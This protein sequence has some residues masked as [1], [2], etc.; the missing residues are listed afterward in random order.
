MITNQ[1]LVSHACGTQRSSNA[2]LLSSRSF[3]PITTL[4]VAAMLAFCCA[5]SAHAAGPLPAGGRFVG[6]NGS[7]AANGST[8]TVN[9]STGRG[10]VNWDSFSIGSGNQVVFANGSGAT[11]NRVTGGKPSAILG[12]LKASGSVYLINPQGIVVGTQGVIATN[13]RF[14]ASTLDTDPVAF[15]NGGPLTLA[16]NSNAGIVNLGKISSSGGDVFLIARSAI[17][18]NGTISAPNGTAEL[19]VAKQVLLQDSSTGKQVFVQAGAGGML[20]NTG[21][22]QAAQVSLQ[23]VDG[24]IYALAGNH[25]AIRATGTATRDGH[26]WLVA[27]HGT[28]RPGGVIDAKGGTVDMQANTLAFPVGGTNVSARQWNISTPTF[29]ID[30]NAANALVKGLNNGTSVNVQTTGANG[31]SGDLNVNAGIGWQ[32]GASLTLAAYHNVTVGSGAT[33]ANQ[34]SGN[35]TLRADAASH[36]NAGSIANHG[37]IDWSRSTGLVNALY[38]MNG[39]YSAG[40]LLGNPSWTAAASSGQLTQITGYKLVNN[41]ND[42]ENIRQDLAGNYALGTD[43][44]ATG[45][46]FTPIGDHTTPFTGQFDGMWH[47][48]SNATIDIDDFH[49][50]SSS[51]LFGVVGSAGVLRDV[52]MENG[53]VSTSPVGSGILAGVNDGV[54]AYAH[55]T[56]RA[57]EVEQNATTFGGL[58][59]KN[60]GTVERSWSS[61]TVSGSN[62]NGGLVGYN[63]GTI[64]QSYATGDV[65]PVFSTGSGGGLVGINDGTVSQSFATGAVQTRSMPTHG[66]IAFGSGTL[67]PDVYWNRETTGQSVSGGDLP[68]TNGLTTAQMSDKAS[69]AGYDFGPD[70]VWLMPSGATHPVLRQ[71]AAQ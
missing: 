2:L 61:A 59:G 15:M 23:S 16:G 60:D 65:S 56:G 20:A 17:M 30:R 40:T 47:T 22:I 58:V 67:A 45:H 18:N 1:R 29:T 24:N 11:L 3:H 49:K 36:D 10:V 32:G 41:V 52:G 43:I 71:P 44:D 25:E 14:V 35:L 57:G 31:R 66:V 46:T 19:A 7:I 26:V 37:V 28:V 12:T 9:Q 53:F 54:I 70:G 5:A 8:L 69:F 64:S 55:T 6:G 51:G 42:L 62:A 34:G 68:T 50:D 33:L 38:D 27:A 48:I 63:L 39:T 4:R 13:G 21:T